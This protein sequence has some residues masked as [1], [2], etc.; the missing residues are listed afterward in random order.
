[1]MTTRKERQVLRAGGENGRTGDEKQEG[2]RGCKREGQ[3]RIREEG[4]G[5]R[6]RRKEEEEEEVGKW[7]RKR[8]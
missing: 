8:I 4:K 5:E 6:R 1:M 2:T 7:R 3:E